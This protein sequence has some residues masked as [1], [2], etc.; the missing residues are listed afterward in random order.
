M[1]TAT[2][3]FRALKE[4]V[5]GHAPQREPEVVPAAGACYVCGGH[6]EDALARLGSTRCHDCRSA[7]MQ[8]PLRAE[9]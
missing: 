2:H 1:Q 8:R 4:L 7:G 5:R 6:V 9:T 3:R